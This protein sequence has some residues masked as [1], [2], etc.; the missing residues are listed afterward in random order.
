MKK[1]TLEMVQTSLGEYVDSSAKQPILILRDGEPVAM[2][3]GIGPHG[4]EKAPAKLRD[5]LRQAWQDFE[6]HGGVP[7][8]EFWAGFA[9]ATVR[10]K[11]KKAGAG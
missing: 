5:V 7:H 10:R 2:L 9:K 4:I 11:K 1:A 6:E 3:V 8:D